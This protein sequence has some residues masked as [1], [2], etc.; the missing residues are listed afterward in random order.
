MLAKN[1]F[2][3]GCCSFSVISGAHPF[4]ELGCCV[5]SEATDNQ[6]GKAA[7]SSVRLVER[8]LR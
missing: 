2:G 7:E 8:F 3:E 6:P 1:A 4:K 5:K